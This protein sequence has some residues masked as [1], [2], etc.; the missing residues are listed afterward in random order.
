MLKKPCLQWDTPVQYIK[1]VGPKLAEVLKKR[2][3]HTV[4][5][6]I[7]WIP[8]TYQDNRVVES[9]AHVP[10]GQPVI[11][12]ACV[13]QKSIVPLRG[14]R[15]N[16]YEILISDSTA[17]ISCKFFRLPYRE[18]FNSLRV[19]DSVEVRGTASLYR[20]RLEFHHPQIF[21]ASSKEEFQPQDLLLPVY[22]ET[23]SLTQNKIRQIM[24]NLLKDIKPFGDEL[25]WLPEWLR[26][27]HHLTDRWTA[28]KGLHQPDL[29][30]IDSVSG[31]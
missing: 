27:K 19:G 14:R 26:Q 1:G 13:Y 24:E 31:L 15:K 29:N 12:R 4:K 23:E 18:W 20:G 25:E 8:R 7:H 3:I 30:Q 17:I 9:L 2:S 16:L 6:L 21:S 10:L 11:V 22:T 5:D 28:L